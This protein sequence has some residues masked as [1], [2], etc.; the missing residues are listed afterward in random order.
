MKNLKSNSFISLMCSDFFTLLNL[1]SIN[2]QEALVAGA[3]FEPTTFG[4]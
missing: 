3:G 2:T 1:Q 4:L